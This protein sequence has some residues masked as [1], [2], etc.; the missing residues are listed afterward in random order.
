MH[1]AKKY[2]F[3]K[4]KSQ[5]KAHQEIFFFQN[6]NRKRGVVS[7]MVLKTGTKKEPEK[8]LISGLLVE[9]VTS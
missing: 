6:E 3:I 2:V 5:Q 8:K 1:Q 4:K 7:S 9:P